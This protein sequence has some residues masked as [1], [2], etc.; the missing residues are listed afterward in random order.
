MNSK[1]N[2]SIIIAKG[3]PVRLPNPYGISF[4]NKSS[5]IRE[6]VLCDRDLAIV[7]TY[8]KTLEAAK[9]KEFKVFTHKKPFKIVKLD[10][11]NFTKPEDK[12]ETKTEEIERPKTSKRLQRLD[13][14]KSSMAEQKRNNSQVR[15]VCFVYSAIFVLQPQF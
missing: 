4:Q 7:K 11:E 8:S 15:H 1:D 14:Q 13:N 2:I 12:L 6:I 10:D 9:G 5:K 3:S